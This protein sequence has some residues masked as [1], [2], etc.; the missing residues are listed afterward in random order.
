MYKILLVDDEVEVRESIARTVEWEKCGFSLC[1]C[2][3]GAL[4]A[5][6][7]AKSLLPDVVMT[8]ICMPYMDGLELIERLKQMYPAMQFVVVSGYDDF[9]YAQKAL[10]YQVMDYLL[11]PLSADGVREALKKIR[12]RLDAEA[13][14]RLDIEGFQEQAR[15]NRVSLERMALMEMLFENTNESAGFLSNVAGGDFFPAHMA[16]M[17]VP[18]TQENQEVLR[19][20]FQGRQDLLYF[21]LQEIAQEL[22]SNEA[23]G[24]CI[25]HRGRFVLLLRCDQEKAVALMS[26]IMDTIRMYLHLSVKAALSTQVRSAQELPALYQRTLLLVGSDATFSGGS[27]FLMEE[28]GPVDKEE[29]LADTLPSEVSQLLRAGDASRID[30]Y[31]SQLRETLAHLRVSPTLLQALCAMVH[32]AV[33]TTALRSGLSGDSILPLL[34][35][36]RMQPPLET[37]RVLDTLRNTVEEAARLIA[38]RNRVSSKEFAGRIAAY[39][40]D[41]YP[42]PAL[43]ISDLCDAFHISQTQLSLIFKREM[44]TSFLQYV[45]DLR[46]SRAQELLRQSDKKI[47]QIALETGFEDPGYFSYCFKQRCG[48]TP[49]NYRQGAGGHA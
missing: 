9:N 12:D 3:A 20:E 21:A 5:M 33:F 27:L 26:M 45:L 28:E 1:G 29:G 2:A 32:S 22:I 18:T 35:K 38:E 39:I 31:F 10:Q 14:R 11:K 40:R 47:Y 34:E 43:S 41:H 44:G 49:K 17:E 15:L 37:E 23:S 46:I 25:C 24:Q 4:E 36:Y 48:V 16:L 6:Q 42:E 7:M 19:R 30:Q 8:D 13:S